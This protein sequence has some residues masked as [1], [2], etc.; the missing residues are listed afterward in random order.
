M[1]LRYY[2]SGSYPYVSLVCSD[3]DTCPVATRSGCMNAKE[4]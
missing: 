4:H 1:R 3:R 2:K